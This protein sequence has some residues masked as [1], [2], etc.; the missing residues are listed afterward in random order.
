MNIELLA[1][2]RD[3]ACGRAAIAH[4]ADAIYLGAD[5]FG[6]REA[7]GNAL[8]EI[9][10]LVREAHAYW[11][12]VYV[13]V[14]TLL[15]DLELPAARELIVALDKLGVDGIIIQDTGLLE[16]S[17]PPIPLIASTQMHNHT[18]ERVAFLEA[19]GLKRA[20]LARELTLEEIRAIR[21]RTTLELE[22]FVHGAIC[23]GYSGQC[24][25]SY[26]LGGRSGNRGQCAQPCRKRYTLT[27]PAGRLPQQALH[28]LS[29]RD[30]NLTEHLGDL[31]DAGVT[32]FKIE[33]RLKDAAYVANVTAHYRAALD[34]ALAARGLRKAA[35]GAGAPDFT[36]DPAKTFNR[37][38][39]R[40]FVGGEANVAAP[41]TPKMVGEPLGPVTA[42]SP[43]GVT[44][45]STLEV[46]PGDGLSYFDADSALQGVAVNGV[47]GN[48]LLLAQGSRPPVGALLY[49]N[50]DH[51]ALAQLEKSRTRRRVAVTLTLSATPDGLR[52]RAVDED[53]V[54]AEATVACAKEPA[55]QPETAEANIRTQLAKTG[56]TIFTCAETIIDLPGAYFFPAA[57]LNALRRDAL[58]A[59]AQAREAAR[60]IAR[61]GALRNDVRF[62]TKSL[63][64]TGNV[65]N[66]GAETFY[67]RH[68]ATVAEPAAES[69][70]VSLQDRTVMT[71]RYCLRRELG[72]CGSEP[73]T[74]LHLTDDEG[75]RLELTFDC[76]RC[77]MTIRVLARGRRKPDM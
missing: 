12:K 17:L 71:T 25:L 27:D 73:P 64:F 15:T 18:P 8:D 7:A 36:P 47:E 74:P 1:P 39:T 48:R 72:R 70:R 52:L 2:V 66:R 43:R 63:D 42:T 45:D 29:L 24:Y 51:A 10:T 57:L 40:Y 14:N 28:A 34:A 16:A 35:S 62:P 11:V 23:V 46:H 37:G 67:R 6:A 38:F 3:L 49:R 44:V 60:P 21:A 61:G 19:V 13:T 5:R 4:G 56:D 20:I 75:N 54:A 58:A 55:R 33:G 69:G 59:L 77:G 31:L 53:G 26:A 9:A 76:A 50:H 65:L 41:A 68:G 32:A 22:V 30:L